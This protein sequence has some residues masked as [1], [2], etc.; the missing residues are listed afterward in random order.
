MKIRF[1][2]LHDALELRFRCC[3]LGCD[4]GVFESPLALSRGADDS[5][6]T[7]EEVH[8][9]RIFPLQY[10][11]SNQLSDVIAHIN[12]LRLCILQYT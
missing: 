8:R 7:P 11:Y 1:N 2:E 6:A 9:G 4:C 10:L 12:R 3:I 5:I